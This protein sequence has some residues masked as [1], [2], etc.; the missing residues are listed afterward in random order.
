MSTVSRAKCTCASWAVSYLH[1]AGVA[2]LITV[3]ATCSTVRDARVAQDPA[4]AVPGERTP[5]VAELGLPV[6]GHVALEDLEQ[7]ALRVHPSI[8]LARHAVQVARARITETEAALLPQVSASAAVS[9]NDQSSSGSSSNTRHR[10]ESLGFDVSWLLFDFGR[11]RA[12]A[13][14]AGG[15]W[16]AAQEDLR[17]AQVDVVFGVRSAYFGLSKQVQLLAV[18][19][20]TVRQF[21]AHLEQA[22]ALVEVGKRIQYDITKA[23][24]DVG[25]ARLAEV[26]ARDAGFTAQ[27]VLANAVGV[28]EVLDWA[29]DAGTEPA[30]A[31][32]DFLEAW[33]QAQQNQP[34]LAAAT[35]R[36]RAAAALVDA[37]VDELYPS[38]D[39]SLGY[40]ASG[41]MFPLPWSVQAGPALRWTPFNGFQ[42]LST[43][44]EAAASLLGARA[45]RAQTE[46]KI[47][48]ELR[49]AWIAIEDARQRLELTTL[50]IRSAEEN[51]TYAQGRFEVGS[52]TSVELTDAQQALAQAR[53]GQVQARADYEISRARFQRAL[54][55][56]AAAE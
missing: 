32:P 31:P 3:F 27:A 39:L 51:L 42:N 46:Q 28:A 18:A 50:T 13:R 19:T 22:R 11:T 29:A 2:A 38:L 44:D 20:E 53:S 48:L 14:S 6:T 55:T 43:I 24:V 4:N 1:R 33:L 15:Q 5:T 41:S 54:G 12:E 45:A 26:Q 56:T 8:L 37:R 9:Y 30:Q 17:T 23:E 16:L 36:E 21:E 35:A 40:S 47:W 34:T 49:S 52:G 7:I 10:F 25:N